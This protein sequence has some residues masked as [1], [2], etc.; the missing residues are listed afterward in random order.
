MA[1]GAHM[2]DAGVR[3]IL[4]S[5]W[6]PVCAERKERGRSLC[7]TCFDRLPLNLKRGTYLKLGAGLNR[8]LQRAIDWLKAARVPHVHSDDHVLGGSA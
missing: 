2:N 7:R 8:M 6:C 1:Q 4:D 3:K 5:Q